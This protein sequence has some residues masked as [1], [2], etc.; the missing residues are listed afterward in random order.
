MRAA[1]HSGT[2]N[3]T[4][5]YV[6]GLW[7]DLDSTFTAFGGQ[8]TLPADLQGYNSMLGNTTLGF[9]NYQAGILKVE[10]RTGHGLTMNANLT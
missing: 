2:G 7:Q 5:E 10:K 3:I 8:P 9:S 4:T 6:Y 1:A